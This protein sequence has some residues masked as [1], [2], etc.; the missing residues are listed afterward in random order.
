MNTY[1]RLS[2][3]YEK[4]KVIPYD[5]NSKIVIMSDCHRGSG[6][7]GDNFLNNQ[8]IFLAALNSYYK[9]GFTY[10]ELGDGDELWENRCMEQIIE[11]H[12]STFELL[13]KF[14]KSNRMYMIYGNHDMQKSDT[15]F[16]ECHYKE[17]YCTIRRTVYSLFTSMKGYEG[18]ILEN[19]DN[20]KNRILLVHGHQGDLIN[21]RLWKLGRFLVRYIWRTLEIWGV[22]DPTRAAKNYRKKNKIERQLMRWSKE[23]N[24]MLIAG[25]THRPSFAQVNKDMYFNSGSCIHP[26][27]I[28]AIEIEN[29]CISLVKWS[30]MIREDSSMYVGKEVLQGP[31]NLEDYFVNTHS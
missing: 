9:M 13:S 22:N 24:I 18:L 4:S 3:V 7:S 14:Y 31:T 23:K 29:S 6:N 5:Y 28:T 11:V 17:Y 10:I 26:T 8:Y 20:K 1:K 16:L 27:A 25:H 2:E 30:V 19:N 15:R 21:D 12:R